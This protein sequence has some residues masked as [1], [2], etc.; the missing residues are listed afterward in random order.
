MADTTTLR[1][2]TVDEYV[3][4]GDAEILQPDERVELVDGQL[5]VSSQV[6]PLE[7]TVRQLLER[8]LRPVFKKGAH[9]R[10]HFPLIVDEWS[11]PEPDVAVVRGAADDYL[12][13]H[14][15]HALLVVEISE[16]TLRIDRK[17]KL[18][19]YAK[20]GIKD[21]WIVSLVEDVVEVYREP[22]KTSGKLEWTYKSVKRV[23]V[24]G[25]VSPLA[26]PR[27][28]IAVASFMR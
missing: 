15:K 7:A 13:D 25:S 3:R 21:Y 27:S 11:M 4:M 20:A 10:P 24:K 22:R 1:R 6:T 19:V 14:P 18:P 17:K 23:T 2:F 26:A 28:K 8:A 9:I 16:T 5:W 12:H